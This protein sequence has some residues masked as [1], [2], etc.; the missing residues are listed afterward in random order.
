VTSLMLED[1]RKRL[2]RAQVVIGVMLGVT[3]AGIAWT[4]AALFALCFNAFAWASWYASLHHSMD[5]VRK[6][7]V[8]AQRVEEHITRH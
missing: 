7:E 8:R 1:A 3:A 5:K 2:R 4:D 6:L